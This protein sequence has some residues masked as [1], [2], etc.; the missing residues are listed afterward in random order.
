M[1]IKELQKVISSAT[2]VKIYVS[3]SRKDA[4]NEKH[5]AEYSMDIY[6]T[7]TGLEDWEVEFIYPRE[8]DVLEAWCIRQTTG[9]SIYAYMPEED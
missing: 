8:K 4:L 9:Q 2:T 6:S 7:I 1:K 3:K 5:E